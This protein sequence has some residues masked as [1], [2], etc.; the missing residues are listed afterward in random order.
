L[1]L[2]IILVYLFG[3]WQMFAIPSAL[4]PNILLVHAVHTT[5]ALTWN[6]PSWSIS[7]EWISYLVFPILFPIFYRSTRFGQV[8]GY[9]I[10]LLG[11]LLTI[12]FLSS[13]STQNTLQDI[14]WNFGFLRGILGFFCGII[15]YRFYQS[16]QIRNFFNRDIVLCLTFILTFFILHRGGSDILAI[17]SF[18]FFLLSVLCNT[19]KLKKVFDWRPLQVLGDISYSIYMWHAIL[20]IVL[21][22]FI[23]YLKI[24]YPGFFLPNPF[25]LSFPLELIFCISF[26]TVLI[27]VSLLSFHFVENPLRYYIKQKVKTSTDPLR[28]EVSKQI[29]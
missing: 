17:I 14:T 11:Y 26:L 21:L 8:L 13:P 25:N 2:V 5:S 16:G 6:L 4:I 3:V 28:L 10:I 1:G 9:L 19:K 22:I 20:V 24:P 12:H 29:Q 27:I 18:S 15:I 23:K 7:A